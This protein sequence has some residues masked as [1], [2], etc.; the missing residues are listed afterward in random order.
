VSFYEHLADRHLT[1]QA[2][3]YWVKPD[4][5]EA[6]AGLLKMRMGKEEVEKPSRVYKRSEETP[7]KKLKWPPMA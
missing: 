1:R 4:I 7:Y 5:C 3:P 2:L 6:V